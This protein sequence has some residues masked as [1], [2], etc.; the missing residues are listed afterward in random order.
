MLHQISVG[1]FW[2]M[3]AFSGIYVYTRKIVVTGRCYVAIKKFVFLTVSDIAP[4]QEMKCGRTQA[5]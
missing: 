1:Y 2:H 5:M 3:M 4:S